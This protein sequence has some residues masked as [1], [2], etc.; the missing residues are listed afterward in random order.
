[1]RTKKYVLISYGSWDDDQDKH[2]F[3]NLSRREVVGIMKTVMD[4]FNPI[5]V[6]V[7]DQDA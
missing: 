2:V 4:N 6:D 7:L 5:H 1:M 3:P